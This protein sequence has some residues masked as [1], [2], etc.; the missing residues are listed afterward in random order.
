[1]AKKKA[2]VEMDKNLYEV[3]QAE[4]EPVKLDEAGLSDTGKPIILRTFKFAFTPEQLKHGTITE[5]RLRRSV[6]FNT[7]SQGT[8][9]AKLK[10]I[11]HLLWVDG[12]ELIEVPRVKLTPDNKGFY[13]FA[14]AQ[15][16]RGHIFSSQDKPVKLQDAI[17]QEPTE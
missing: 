2:K 6:N 13:V 4:T 16:R 9:D 11:E 3:E 17:T 12:L 14:T 1:M 15:A 8:Q 5:D 7:D 10:M